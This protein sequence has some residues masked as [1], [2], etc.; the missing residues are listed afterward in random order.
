MLTFVVLQVG[1]CVVV[2]GTVFN[3]IHKS[4]FFGYDRSGTMHWIIP[5]PREQFGAEGLIMAL[6]VGGGGL[7]WIILA[8]VMPNSKRPKIFI[9]GILVITIVLMLLGRRLFGWKHPYYPY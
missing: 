6:I 3:I 4:P 2:G 5:S 7:G 1:Y 8:G 9:L